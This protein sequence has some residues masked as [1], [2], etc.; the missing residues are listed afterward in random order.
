MK[1][2]LLYEKIL[3]FSQ[4]SNPSALEQSLK[5]EPPSLKM[6]QSEA[7]SSNHSATA[8]AALALVKPSTSQR[9]TRMYRKNEEV[10]AERKNRARA[11]ENCRAGD[12]VGTGGGGEATPAGA[13]VGVW[14]LHSVPRVIYGRR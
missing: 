3:L 13:G 6:H 7:Q 8:K 12:R 10:I 9:S 5:L 4:L 11:S 2:N 1:D 14:G